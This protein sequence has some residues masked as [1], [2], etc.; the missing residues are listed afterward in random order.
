MSENYTLLVNP[1][2]CQVSKIQIYSNSPKNYYFI[3][4]VKYNFSIFPFLQVGTDK[5]I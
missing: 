2:V 5:Q 4:N 3:C 1:I